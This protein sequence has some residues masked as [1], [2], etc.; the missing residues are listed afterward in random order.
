[1]TAVFNNTDLQ[2]IVMSCFLAEVNAL[3]P[4]NV[5]RYAD[6][7]GMTVKDY[8]RSAE[9][10]TPILCNKALTAGERIL[11]SVK[12]TMR[13]VGC[14]TNLGMVLLFAPVIRATEVLNSISVAAL[15]NQLLAELAAID[16]QDTARVCEAIC[17]ANPGGLGQSDKYDVNLGVTGSLNEAMAEASQRDYIAKQYVTDFADVFLTGLVCIKEF[18]RRWNSVEW[19]V[20]ACYLTF[21]AEFPDSHIQR[22]L[23]VKAAQ[24]TRTRAKTIAGQFLKNDNPVNAKNALLEFDRELKDSGKN[25]GTSADLTA[26]SLLVYELTK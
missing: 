5:N 3:K 12:A 2:K 17:L 20:V 19:A 24:Q 8:I 25:P 26:A 21:L 13:Q 15:Q 22:K 16:Q 7:H 4:G 1:M 11:E 18:I 9:L 6:G 23:G 14:N 10:V